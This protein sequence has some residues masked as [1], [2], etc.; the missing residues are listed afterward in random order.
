[1]AAP[2]LAGGSHR[3]YLVPPN[4]IHGPKILGVSMTLSNSKLIIR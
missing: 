1:M 2:S 4:F 3:P